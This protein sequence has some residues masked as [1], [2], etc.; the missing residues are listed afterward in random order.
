MSRAAWRLAA[1]LLLAASPTASAQ[2]ASVQEKAHPLE[3]VEHGGYTGGQIGLLFMNAPGEGGGLA[4]GSLVGVNVGYDFTSWLG[5]GVFFLSG[6]VVAP[7]DYSGLSG[8]TVTGD[9]TVFLP[10]AEVKFHLPLASDG[11]GTDRLFLELGVGAGALFPRPA[12]LIVKGPLATAKADL[13]LE[14]FTRLRHLSVGLRVDGFIAPVKSSSALSAL[15][16]SPFIRYS[17]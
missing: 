17:F 7:N 16:I 11:N 15:G 9:F 10:G 12:D 3:E 6:A 2:E 14:Y 1:L 4:V 13:G 5:A 8:G